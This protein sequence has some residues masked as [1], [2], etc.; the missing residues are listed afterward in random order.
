MHSPNTF[1]VSGLVGF[2]EE[3][4]YS[5]LNEA[6]GLGGESKMVLRGVLFLLVYDCMS[7]LYIFVLYRRLRGH[8]I[9]TRS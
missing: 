5:L 4:T 2:T 7:Y 6:C 1:C 8:L 3:I 9:T